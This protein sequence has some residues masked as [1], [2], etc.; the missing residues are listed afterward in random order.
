MLV[1]FAK[2]GQNYYVKQYIK[3]G[4]FVGGSNLKLVSESE[5]EKSLK[6]SKQ[7]ITGTCQVETIE[8]NPTKVKQID[9]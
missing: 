4:V 7:A 3:P 9:S 6:K 5:A 1:F 8:I 2:S